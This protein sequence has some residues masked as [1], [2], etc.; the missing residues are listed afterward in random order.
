MFIFDQIVMYT[1]LDTEWVFAVVC[2]GDADT[3]L[4]LNIYYV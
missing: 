3:P 2:I 4:Q 1:E